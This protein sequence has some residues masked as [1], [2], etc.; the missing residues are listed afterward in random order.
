VPAIPTLPKLSLTTFNVTPNGYE[1]AY[2]QSTATP[3][4]YPGIIEKKLLLGKS[5][6]FNYNP[7]I[8]PSILQNV[9]VYLR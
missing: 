6:Y 9:L 2:I 8:V 4:S 7:G 5:L 1:I 3:E